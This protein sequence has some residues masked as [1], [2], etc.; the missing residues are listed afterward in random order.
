VQPSTWFLPD[1]GANY[2]CDDDGTSYCS[3][4][5]AVRCTECPRPIDEKI[6]EDSLLN[7]N[8]TEETQWIMT[9]DLYKKLDE[10][11]DLLGSDP[12]LADFYAE[13]QGTL[14][15]QFKELDDAQWQLFNLDS[16]ILAT[17]QQNQ[18]QIADLMD[19]VKDAIEQLA[20]STLTTA[21]RQL[22][23]STIGGHQQT[24]G[25]LTTYN[26]SALQ[27]V[28][29]SRVLAA[30]N[31]KATNAALGTSE[32]IESNQQQVNDIFL[33]TVAKD[34]GA[35]TAAQATQL[36]D[37]ANQCPMLGGNAVFRARAL[38]SL[39]DDTQDFNDPLICLQQGIIVKSVEASKVHVVAIV[40]N[41]ATDE[42]I[43]VLE[44]EWDTPGVFI[45][46]NALGAEALHLVVPAHTVRY[47]FSTASLAPAVYHFQVRAPS[48]TVCH[49]KMS[50]VR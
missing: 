30:D 34:V 19:L 25:N 33:G 6:A 23:L 20:D 7:G 44:Q 11:P 4:F 3:Q 16:L 37:I 9:G 1:G 13:Q 15:A 48:G 5:Y 28:A 2:L 17:L 45:I 14:I 38:Y 50:I 29:D 12:L 41:P 10:S 22:L 35:F 43:L 21:Q 49:G 18:Q 26:A 8:Y 32:L 24:I 36:F 47:S 42:A 31:V 46:H 40:P 27:L 39:I